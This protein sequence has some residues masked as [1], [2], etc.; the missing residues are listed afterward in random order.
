MYHYALVVEGPHNDAT[1]ITVV[2]VKAEIGSS[3]FAIDL[4]VREHGKFSS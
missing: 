4:R 1:E 2:S 3:S